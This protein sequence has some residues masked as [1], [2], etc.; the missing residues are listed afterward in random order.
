[1]QNKKIVKGH[2]QMSSESKQPTKIN[3][4]QKVKLHLEQFVSPANKNRKAITFNNINK[5][6]VIDKKKFEQLELKEKGNK[7][8]NNKQMSFKNILN[9]YS[10]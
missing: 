5:K 7:N 10:P 8:D 3:Y 1:M 9:L 2:K 4:S 6:V